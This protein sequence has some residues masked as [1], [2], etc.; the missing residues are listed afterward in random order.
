VFRHFGN[1]FTTLDLL[2]GFL[3]TELGK[4]R[5]RMCK[6]HLIKSPSIIRHDTVKDGTIS[7]A[8]AVHSD[9]LTFQL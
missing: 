9:C 5:N 7:I 2:M 6:H 3:Q 4:S 8:K 1:Y